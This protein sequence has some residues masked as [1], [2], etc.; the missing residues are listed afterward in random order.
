MGKG[1][2]G[3]YKQARDTAIQQYEQTPQKGP[4]SDEVLTEFLEATKAQEFAIINADK[5]RKLFLTA[6]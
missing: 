3:Q 4:K 1:C 6:Y 2:F 5:V